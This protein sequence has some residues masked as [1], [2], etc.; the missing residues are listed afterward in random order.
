MTIHQLGYSG[1]LAN[2]NRLERTENEPLAT[3]G[4]VPGPGPPGLTVPAGWRSSGTPMVGFSS[5]VLPFRLMVSQAAGRRLRGGCVLLATAWMLL[6]GSGHAQVLKLPLPP[7]T[8]NSPADAKAAAAKPAE[9]GEEIGQKLRK[10][11]AEVRAQLATLE[12]PGPGVIPEGVASEEVAA[13]RADLVRTAYSLERH[14]K[15]IETA[16]SAAETTKEAQRREKDWKGF[17]QK[18]PFSFLFYDELR[19]QRDSARAKLSAHQSSVALV[20]RQIAVQQ[21]EYRKVEEASRRV[22]DDAARASGTATE[23]AALWRLESA[24]IRLRAI[25]A[26]MASYK[27]A[28]STTQSRAAAAAADLALFERQLAAIGT[29][30]SFTDKDLAA[31][32]EN[33]RT[34]TA[35]VEKEIAALTKRQTTVLAERERC[36]AEVDKL[37]AQAESQPDK[38]RAELELAEARMRAIETDFEVLTFQMDVLSAST[39]LHTEVPAALGHRR[40]LF[41]S[42]DA[43]QRQ[44]ARADLQAMSTRARNWSVFILNERAVINAAIREVEARLANLT[45]ESPRHPIEQRVLEAQRR[46]A[47]TLD[48][49]EQQIDNMGRNLDRWLSDYDKH[50]NQRSISQRLAD[51]F[52]GAWDV[53]RKVWFFEIYSYTDHMEFNGETIEVRRG[54]TLGWFLG[55]LVFFMVFYWAASWVSRRIQHTAVERG[56]TGEAQS[57][58]LRRW[59]MLAVG[60]VLMLLTLHLL[61]IPL[62]AFAFLGGALAIGVGFGTQTIFKNFISGIIV[63]VERKVK[64]G[65]ILDVDG[66]V[67]TV[68]TVDTRSSTIRGFDGVE[69]LVPNSLLLENKVTN[70]THSNARLRRVVR[71]GV[72]YGSPVQQVAEIMG[73]AAGRHGLILK[74][75]APQVLFEDFGA[76]SLVFALFFWVELNERTNANVV[77]SDLRFMLDKRFREAGVSIAFPQRDL[78]LHSSGPLRVELAGTAPPP[79]APGKHPQLP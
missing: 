53:V 42:P 12:A 50:L 2:Q 58:T 67:G 4:R 14:L 7:A 65:D 69:T 72:A 38:T 6:A 16:K 45:E 59:A 28:T 44:K 79:E 54:L 39:R 66:I 48:R 17:E 56:W 21:D 52:A 46:K 13:R 64:V 24:Q 18:P 32:A 23:A 73:E 22:A 68:T 19:N 30:I 26:T 55:A 34:K 27:V 1:A 61:R 76:D 41:T 49:I 9:N 60:V 36:R 31:A 35:A 37:R 77:A 71:V 63:L 43:E 33:S 29:D 3:V 20:E 47:E 62:T 57:R 5:V 15:S 74:D 40:L 8:A 78:H 11:L 70:W 10:S 75:P 51:G 25:G